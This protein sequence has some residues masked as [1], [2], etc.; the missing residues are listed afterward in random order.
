MGKTLPRT[1]VKAV[2]LQWEDDLYLAVAC[3]VT[4]PLNQHV[5]GGALFWLKL[6]CFSYA[7]D[8]VLMLISSNLHKKSSEVPIETRSPPAPFSFKDRATM[9][10]THGKM[11][12]LSL[13]V[14]IFLTRFPQKSLFFNHVISCHVF[15]PKQKRKYA[16]EWNSIPSRIGLHSQFW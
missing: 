5:A 7:S 12:Y 8:A 13:I 3:L 1:F 9:K 6:P 2:I 15:Q 14:R 10:D 11:V 16:C 4:W